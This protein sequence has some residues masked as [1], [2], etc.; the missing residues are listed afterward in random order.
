MPRRVPKYSLHKATGQARVCIDGTDHY[1]GPHGSPESRRKYSELVDRWK[2]RQRRA[3]IPEITIGQLAL[4]YAEY[5]DGYY[6]K[7]GEPTSEAAC[8]RYA[9]R[10]LV[11]AHANLAAPGFGPKRLKAVRR[12]MIG[13]EWTRQSINKHVSRI[14]RMFRWAVAEEHVVTA[15]Y[16]ALRAVPGLRKGRTDAVESDPVQPVAEG[17][18]TPVG[19][20]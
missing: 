10:A 20:C 3:H 13:L 9:L 11:K 1:L 19:V 15:V 6:R 16:E 4:L 17:C 7:H 5:A 14:V 8:I 2:E 12:E 18:S